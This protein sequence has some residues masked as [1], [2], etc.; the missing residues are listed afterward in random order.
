MNNTRIDNAKNRVRLLE[1]GASRRVFEELIEGMEE[2][3]DELF[4]RLEGLD[5]RLDSIE[6]QAP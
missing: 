5:Q 2:C 1:P 3:L 4:Q 6:G